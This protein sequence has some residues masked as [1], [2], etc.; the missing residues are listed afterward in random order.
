MKFADLKIAVKIF[1]LIGLVSLLFIGVMWQLERILLD[2]LAGYDKVR[3]IEELSDHAVQVTLHL[4]QARRWENEFLLSGNPRHI[5]TTR[6]RID[7]AIDQANQLKIDDIKAKHFD[8]VDKDAIIISR[9]HNYRTKFHD[10]ANAAIRKGQDPHSGIR[11]EFLH[12]AQN[13]ERGIIDQ[14]KKNNQISMIMEG[15]MKLHWA[16][17]ENHHYNDS[18]IYLNDAR[19]KIESVHHAIAT[20]NL[21]TEGKNQLNQLLKAYYAVFDRLTAND[22][23]L[24]QRNVEMQKTTTELEALIT[25]AQVDAGIEIKTISESTDLVAHNHI[26]MSYKISF[27]AI[28]LGGILSYFLTGTITRQLVSIS[29]TME[30]VAKS[31]DF[32]IR[33]KE[34]SQDEVGRVG[35]AFNQMAERTEQQDWLKSGAETLANIVQNAKTPEDFS[36]SLIG[37]LVTLTGAGY[38][39]IFYRREDAAHYS[40]L[41]SSGFTKSSTTD[42]GIGTAFVTNEGLAGR[43]AI[44]KK[45]IVLT[46]TPKGFIRIRS[47]FGEAPPHTIIALPLVFQKK[48]LGVIEIA[49]FNPFTPLQRT[50]LDELS[51]AIALGLENLMRTTSHIQTL[52]DETQAQNEELQLQ[53]EELQQSNDQLNQR[54][55]ALKI[56]EEKLKLQQEELL[57]SNRLLSERTEELETNQAELERAQQETEKKAGDLEQASQYKSEFLA[58]MSHELRTPLNSLLILAKI[59]ADN[60]EGNLSNEQIESAQIIHKNG[61]DL[62]Y[63]INDIL[64]LSKIEAGKM[65]VHMATVVINV[66]ANDLYRHFEHVAREKALGWRVEVA[67]GVPEEIHTDSQK[68][69]QILN[70]FLTNAFKFTKEGEITLLFHQPPENRRLP[71][72]VL[73]IEGSDP[74]VKRNIAITVTDTGI[75]IPGEKQYAIFEA[76]QQAD[77]TTSRQYGGTGLGL[78]IARNLAQLL[79]G[80]IR[81]HSTEEK[82]S[83]FTLLLPTKAEISGKSSHKPGITFGRRE[84]D[85]DPFILDDRNILTSG[86][87][88]FLVIENDPRLASLACTLFHQK[89][90]KSLAAANGTSG[91]ILAKRYQPIGILFG[92]TVPDMD[93][94]TLQ[95]ELKADPETSQIPVYEITAMEE[96]LNALANG[97]VGVLT[98]PVNETQL[99]KAVKVLK[100]FLEENEV[101]NMLLLED[102]P[103]A[104]KAIIAL[105]KN[106]NYKII[107]ASSGEEAFELLQQQ[108]FDCIILDIGLPGISGL[109]LLDKIAGEESMA[110]PPIIVY[111]GRDLSIEDYRRLRQYTDSIVLK[112]QGSHSTQRL[113]D[114]MAG[115]LKTTEPKPSLE[116]TSQAPIDSTMEKVFQNEKILVAD[117][118]MRNTFALVRALK[119]KG[120]NVVAAPDGKRALELLDQNPDVCCVLMDIMMPEMDGY[121]AMQAIRKQKRFQ[122]LPIIA[123]TAKAMAEDREKCMQAGANDFLSKPVDMAKLFDVI[124]NLLNQNDAGQEKT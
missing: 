8:D 94:L 83:A 65:D 98:K 52:L 118:D 48:V 22:K 103:I 25:E 31:G 114:E 119:M 47:N 56:S 74:A 34:T 10:L 54:T 29:N 110:Q 28:L 90:F 111:T 6:E 17:D 62:L 79:G 102:D 73:R 86:D 15:Y 89:G 113:M 80:E 75:G 92:D 120:L 85:M 84:T 7:A 108:R 49:S 97:T 121:Q 18:E 101:R 5:D 11:G 60:E 36:Q 35:W 81:L 64:D 72:G 96:E 87:K 106:E 77:G 16:I 51:P 71:D 67:S 63:L 109:D 115:F 3:E 107:Q 24:N 27:A 26:E 123:L 122:K 46:G 116:K 95:T 70:N 58:N 41:A 105:L 23:V 59:F 93:V 14:I 99:K 57:A 76:F 44:E 61:F 69:L 82:G 117:D 1:G 40:L 78:S 9:L 38:G 100:C 2:T 4:A 12:A 21:S 37:T 112:D 33:V 20:S 53:Q 50:L 45:T 32:S 13:L 66:F 91:M 88:A 104:R 19:T 30:E 68:L 124:R 43:C 55:Q 39:A 42:T